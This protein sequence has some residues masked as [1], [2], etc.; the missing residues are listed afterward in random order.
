MKRLLRGF[1][2]R[3][4]VLKHPLRYQRIDLTRIQLYR[5]SAARPSL[6]PQT[7]PSQSKL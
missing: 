5:T 2:A 4:N 3:E 6:Y 1:L 7:S